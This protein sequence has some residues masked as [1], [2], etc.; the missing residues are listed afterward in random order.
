MNVRGC[1][2][3]RG[4]EAHVSRFSTQG[5]SE[6]TSNTFSADD[7]SVTTR[8]RRVV[9]VPPT[10]V[11]QRP[12]TSDADRDGNDSTAKRCH[13]GIIMSDRRTAAATCAHNRVKRPARAT[14]LAE[15]A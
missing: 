15:S 2:P 10:V 9:H 6:R 8:S 3:V 12:T 1:G 11:T 14:L 13:I 4:P 7:G 5:F